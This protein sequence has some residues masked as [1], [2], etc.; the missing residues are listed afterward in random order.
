MVEK[1]IWEKFELNKCTVD[2]PQVKV[3]HI[4]SQA[5]RMTAYLW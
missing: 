5:D 4:K 1:I 2:D 3:L